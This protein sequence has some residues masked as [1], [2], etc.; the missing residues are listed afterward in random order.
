[1][2][3]G[4]LLMMSFGLI[5]LV[6]VIAIPIVLI[7]VLVWAVTK[8]GQTPPV[9]VPAGLGNH[10]FQR[11]CSHCGAALQTGWTHCPQCGAPVA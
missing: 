11:A 7:T 5:A 6:L 3:F 2:M 8:R 10:P 1:M 9:P 4:G